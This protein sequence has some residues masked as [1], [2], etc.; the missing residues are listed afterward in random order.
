MNELNLVYYDLRNEVDKLENW[1][2]GQVF[3]IAVFTFHRI[4][5]PG[6]SL[7]FLRKTKSAGAE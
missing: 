5:V 4:T 7:Q 2:S 3:I 6:I 1:K